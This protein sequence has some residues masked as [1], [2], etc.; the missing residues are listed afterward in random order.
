MHF[1]LLK[2]LDSL[3]SPVASSHAH[4]RHRGGLYVMITPVF[5]THGISPFPWKK[6]DLVAHLVTRGN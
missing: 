3:H 5:I 6:P 1:D 4:I 2:L